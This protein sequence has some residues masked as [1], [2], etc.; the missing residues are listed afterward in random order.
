MTAMSFQ[1]GTVQS[2][3]EK[4][5]LEISEIPSKV[6]S[7]KKFFSPKHLQRATFSRLKTEFFIL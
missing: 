7:E 3:S 1:K 4:S 2:C 6:S 5:I